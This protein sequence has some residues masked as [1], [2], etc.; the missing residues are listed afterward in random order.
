MFGGKLGLL[1][2]SEGFCDGGGRCGGGSNGNGFG[3]VEKNFLH[4]FSLKIIELD[5]RELNVKDFLGG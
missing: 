5:E 3:N 4:D 1:V 2:F